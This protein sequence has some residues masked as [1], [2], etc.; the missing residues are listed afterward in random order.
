MKGSWAG[1]MGQ[2]QF[3]PSSF[4]NY[5]YDWDNDGKKDIWKNK[6]DVF[7]SAANYLS[8][9]GWDNDT[10]WGRKVYIKE[11]HKIKRKKIWLTINDWKK[12][13]VLNF[14]KTE[15]P[16]SK[17]KARLISIDGNNKK[18]YFLVYNNFESLL[19]WNRSNYFGVAVGTLSDKLKNDE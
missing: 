17:I 11:Y 12:L 8:K 13:N 15:L 1:A 5:A 3:M 19:K 9:V 14:D 2:C 4:I 10:T 6:K 16:Y 7:A 18:H